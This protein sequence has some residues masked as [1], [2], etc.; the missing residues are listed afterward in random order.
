MGV[1]CEFEEHYGPGMGRWVLD[2][3]VAGAVAGA[4]ER[5][6]VG[7]L[8]QLGDEGEEFE[9]DDSVA[10]WYIIPAEDGGHDRDERW[11]GEGGG[12]G[13]IEW[14]EGSRNGRFEVHDV[15]R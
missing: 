15:F 7:W 8:G 2:I 11:D 12:E 6:G 1:D 9:T 3:W 10:K 13:W 4:G 14:V 5:V